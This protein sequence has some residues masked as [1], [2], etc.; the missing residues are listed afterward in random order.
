MLTDACDMCLDNTGSV[1]E[2]GESIK[3]LNQ[4]IQYIFDNFRQLVSMEVGMPV[5]ELDQLV[6]EC[7]VSE[8]Q[9]YQRRFG[10]LLQT[11]SQGLSRAFGLGPTSVCHRRRG[12]PSR[13][14]TS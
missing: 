4:A 3:Y 5:D 12:V 14:A 2:A 10:S 1:L 7:D 8:P 11:V 9:N 6:G 13:G